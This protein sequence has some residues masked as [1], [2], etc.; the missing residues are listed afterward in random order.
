LKIFWKIEFQKL[1]ALRFKTRGMDE[2]FLTFMKR[3]H[4]PPSSSGDPLKTSE[5]TSS[6]ENP[7]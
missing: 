2:N 3:K 5:D 7:A 1:K 4:A 6:K